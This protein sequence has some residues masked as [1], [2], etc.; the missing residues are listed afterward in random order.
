[1][2]NRNN[3]VMRTNTTLA[4]TRNIKT[5]YKYYQKNIGVNG[6]NITEFITVYSHILSM[7]PCRTLCHYDY[8]SGQVHCVLLVPYQLHLHFRS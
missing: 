8:L 1:M 3:N 7:T 6:I 2:I 4:I 5:L